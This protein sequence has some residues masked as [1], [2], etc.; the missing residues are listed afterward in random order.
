MLKHNLW[1]F[2]GFFMGVVKATDY[3]KN[4][5]A[6]RNDAEFEYGGTKF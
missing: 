2:M 3:G 4:A 5:F 1:V 6:P